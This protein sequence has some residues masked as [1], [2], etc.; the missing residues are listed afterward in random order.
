MADI[1]MCTN[2][3]CPLRQI[4][5]RQTAPVNEFWQSYAEF[6]YTSSPAADGLGNVFACEHFIR[7]NT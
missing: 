2:K 5:Y 3:Q 1:T 4:C 7:V 6:Q